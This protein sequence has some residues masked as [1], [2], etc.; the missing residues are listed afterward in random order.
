MSE[1]TPADHRVSRTPEISMPEFGVIEFLLQ[2]MIC[3]ETE[4]GQESPFADVTE[5][6]KPAYLVGTK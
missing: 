3:D 4:Q 1:E 2:V 6:D 5:Y